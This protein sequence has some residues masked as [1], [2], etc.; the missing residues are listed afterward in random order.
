[1]TAGILPELS[2]LVPLWRISPSRFTALKKCALREVLTAARQPELLPAF[3]QAR[4]GGIIHKLLEEAGKG[5]VEGRSAKSVE[6]RWDELVGE[7][8]DQMRETW[9]EHSLVPLK[10][11]VPDYEVRRIR[12]LRRAEQ[13]TRE[14]PKYYSKIGQTP[15]LGFEVWVESRDKLVAG[16]IDFV[17][18]TTD[19]LILYDYKTGHVLDKQETNN[20]PQIK[21]EYQ[22]QLKLYAALYEASY[23]RWPHMLKILPLQGDDQ[24]IQ[25][26]PSECAKLLKEAAATLRKVNAMISEDTGTSARAV[27][28]SLANPTPS[29]CCFCQFRPGC[30]A[31][32]DARNLAEGEEW[33]KDV[34]GNVIEIKKLGNGRCSIKLRTSNRSYGE[35]QIRGL[36][37]NPSRHPALE[38]IKEGDWVGVYNLQGK[39]LAGGF[40]ERLSTILYQIPE[41]KGNT[42]R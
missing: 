31:Y 33:P 5:I 14:A 4:L 39:A 20:S 12:A 34:W 23:D 21:P 1:M 15:G 35:V 42:S 30:F 22:V 19:G 29:T 38:F 7:V 25:Y 37:Q 32:Q 26:H 11:T 41:Q 6:S 18:E 3:P 17:Q 16:F 40:S 10:R 2:P 24:I 28:R 8:E 36:T 9:L 27:A 13:F